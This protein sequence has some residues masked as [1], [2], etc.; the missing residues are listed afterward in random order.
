M[1]QADHLKSA[2]NFAES[3]AETVDDA[4]GSLARYGLWKW[5][6]GYS[7]YGRRVIPHLETRQELTTF[8]REEPRPFVLLESREAADN[9]LDLPGAESVMQQE[10][11]GR[12][13][14]LFRK[15]TPTADH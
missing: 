7:Y 9:R 15:R 4:D 5:R 8:W 13:A 11:G 3:M 12:V 14:T 1:P 2:S 10:V 6:A